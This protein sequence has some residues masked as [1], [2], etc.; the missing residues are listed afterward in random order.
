VRLTRN[1]P[2]PAKSSR[3]CLPA[4]STTNRD[5]ASIVTLMIRECSMF[6]HQTY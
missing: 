3:C 1:G 6:L 2:S 4:T 5:F